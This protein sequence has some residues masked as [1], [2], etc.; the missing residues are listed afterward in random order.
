MP[1]PPAELRMVET[2][3]RGAEQSALFYEVAQGGP[4]TLL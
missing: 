3:P 1:P 2:G 4:I